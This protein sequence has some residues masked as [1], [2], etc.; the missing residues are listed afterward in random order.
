MLC[1]S[2]TADENHC[3]WTPEIGWFLRVW[4][5]QKVET[6]AT[7]LQWWTADGNLLLGELN[8]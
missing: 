5:R 8:K 2:A 6:T 3:Y 7:Y 4:H 1:A